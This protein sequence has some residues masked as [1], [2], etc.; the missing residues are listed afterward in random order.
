M[1]HIKNYMN[2]IE[3][4]ISSKEK[5]AKKTKESKGLLSP[6]K[7]SASSQQTELDVIVAFVQ[8]IRQSREEMKNG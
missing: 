3:A 6:T 4:L 1:Q 7:P 2:K 8:S 5:G